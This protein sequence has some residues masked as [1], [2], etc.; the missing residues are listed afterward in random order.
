MKQV[1]Q[2]MVLA[3][4]VYEDKS[5]KKIIAGKFNGLLIGKI[6]LQE[7]VQ[8]DGS[9]HRMIPGG[10]DFGCPSLYISLTDLVDRTELRREVSNV[11]KNEVLFGTAFH[12]Q[13]TDRLATVELIAPLP[14]LTNYIWEPGTF[15]FDLIWHGEILGFA[16]PDRP[17]NR[18]TTST[19]RGREMMI[20]ITWKNDA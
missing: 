10:T 3:E 19:C 4:R 18:T 6:P 8:P 2:A 20:D 15:S 1:L 9:R 13:Q 14:L 7:I 16:S 12:I 17:G 5:G 11:T